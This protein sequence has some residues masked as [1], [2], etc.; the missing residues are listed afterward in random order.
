VSR[1]RRPLAVLALSGGTLAYEVLLVRAF[2]IEQFHHFAYL[3]VGVAMLGFGASGTALAVLRARRPIR[4]DHWLAAA[5]LATP[6]A[7]LAVPAATDLVPIDPTRLAWDLGQ[8]ARLLVLQALLA[9]PF[10]LGA[11]GTLAALL[12]AEGRPGLVYGASFLGAGLGAL[13]GVAVLAWLDPERALALPSLLAVPAGFAAATAAPRPGWWRALAAL[14]LLGAGAAA[15]RPPWRLELLPYKGLAQVRAFPDARVV[16]EATSPTGWMVAVAAPAFRFAPGL[17]LGYHGEFPTQTA[18]FVDGELAGAVASWNPASRELL[19]WQ[20]AALPYALGRPE[21]VLLLTP[22]GAHEVANALAHGAREITA[23]E[24]HPGVAALAR[25][26]NPGEGLGGTTAPVTWAI[27]DG[28]RFLARTPHRYDLVTLGPFAGGGPGA[29]TVSL[30][31]DFL[32][33]VEGY[34]RCLEALAP[35]GVLAVT[36]WIAAPPRAEVRSVLTA[37]AALRRLGRTGPEAA[38]VVVRSWGTVTTLV[39][40]EGFSPADLDRIARWTAA[41]WFDVDWRPGISAPATRFN[42]LD[43]PVLFDAAQ[44]SAGGERAAARFAAAYPFD[45]R[46]ATDARPY[47]HAF[48]GRRSLRL[49]LER[50]RGEWLPFA[51]WG[52]LAVLATLVQGAVLAALLLALPAL[53]VRRGAGGDRRGRLLS[54]FGAL[55]LAYLLAEI[56]AIQQLTLLL[57]HPVYA[58]AA[59]LTAMLVG[60]GVGSA[61]SDRLAPARARRVTLGLALACGALAGGLLPLVHAV[62][63]AGLGARALAAA[64]VLG[65]LAAVMGMPFPLGLRRLAAEDPARVAWAWA[66]NGFGSVV[67]APLAAL[68]ALEAGSE[69]VFAAAAA[70]YAVAGYETLR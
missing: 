43:A 6:A 39:K 23:V 69:A 19:D 64:L 54:Y 3:A 51:E 31:E 16:A 61:W 36:D 41:R 28:R 56:A 38:L 65:P 53:F 67:A 45:V 29:G 46:P 11:L 68:I 9:V 7:L 10:A 24:L 59:V 22:G 35:G 33:T 12:A 21:R 44:A 26:G 27:G 14:L 4:P 18:L 30:R 1:I 20:P 2:A 13:A 70:A 34:L 50:D 66:A 63:G 5:A 17:S 47:P 49:M 62:E 25:R 57:G 37:A 48:L 60:S 58:V 8:G 55:G 32:R 42:F 40:P 52:Y 15:V